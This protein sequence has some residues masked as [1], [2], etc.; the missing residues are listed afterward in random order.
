MFI[1]SQTGELIN[2]AYVARI[3][4][5]LN[6]DATASVIGAIPIPTVAHSQ[7]PRMYHVRL[8]LFKTEEE[9]AAYID[10]ISVLFGAVTPQPYHGVAGALEIAEAEL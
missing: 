3:Y 2:L 1:R 10:E 6:P 9:A 7:Q 4:V 5:D 8:G